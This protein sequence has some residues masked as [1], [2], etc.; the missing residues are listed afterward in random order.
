MKELYPAPPK[1]A[2]KKDDKDEPSAEKEKPQEMMP[3][4]AGGRGKGMVFLVKR[5]SWEV[6]WSGYTPM[7]DHRQSAM[8]RDA[9]RLVAELKKARN[10]AK[11][12]TLD[13]K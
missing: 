4:A 10:P 3:A 13:G 12:I 1:P 5:G 7:G 9:A 6:I 8:N 11:T 2:P